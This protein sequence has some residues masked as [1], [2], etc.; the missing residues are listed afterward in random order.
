MFWN[1]KPH[2]G[3]FCTINIVNWGNMIHGNIYFWLSKALL[4]SFWVESMQKSVQWD[5]WLFHPASPRWKINERRFF[6]V[7]RAHIIPGR[8]VA[9][10]SDEREDQ[11]AR[12]W[13]RVDLSLSLS[14]RVS[15][16]AL[17]L[18]LQLPECV[19]AGAKMRDRGPSWRESER[20]GDEN[21]DFFISPLLLCACAS[22]CE[23]KKL[24]LLRQLF[25]FLFFRTTTHTESNQARGDELLILFCP[26]DVALVVPTSRNINPPHATN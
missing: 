23:W 2:A 12:Y 10:N 24:Q 19:F 26:E 25:C 7:G 13:V 18:S 17:I 15:I 21:L 1:T 14:L 6:S 5:V 3:W 11:R 8:S 20:D 9:E 22:P 4:W 16:S